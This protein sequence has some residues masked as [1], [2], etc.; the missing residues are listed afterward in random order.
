MTRERSN[1]QEPVRSDP[2]AEMRRIVELPGSREFTIDGTARLSAAVDEHVIDR[3]IGRHLTLAGVGV[4]AS[5]S[6]S[7]PGDIGSIASFGSDGDPATAWTGEFGPQAGQWLGYEVDQPVTF[8]SM[9]LEVVVDELHSVPTEVEIALDGSVVGTFATGLT[10]VD[11]P[12]GT[13]ATVEIPGGRHGIGDRGPFPRRRRAA[14][15]GL[16]RATTSWRCRCRSP[17]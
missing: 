6:G 9:G 14:D 16:V 3:L 1:P 7:L 5:S 13:V 15:P 17:R 11:A 2:E 4:D 12:R 8:S 10:L